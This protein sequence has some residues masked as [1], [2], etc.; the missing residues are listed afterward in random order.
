MNYSISLTSLLT[1]S[2]SISGM[3][4]QRGTSFSERVPIDLCAM[5]TGLS[6]R[7]RLIN[8][9][10][11][12]LEGE[13]S[14]S[15]IEATIGF[16]TIYGIQC[17][18]SN[19]TLKELEIFRN[20]KYNKSSFVYR[21]ITSVQLECVLDE[22]LFLHTS[23][24]KLRVFSHFSGVKMSQIFSGSVRLSELDSIQ[25]VFRLNMFKL[26]MFRLNM[27]RLNMFK[28]NMFR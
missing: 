12:L 19:P 13:T 11:F 2:L 23:I 6:F 7:L 8:G 20:K 27:L 10:E 22:S 18:L 15:S 4:G 17:N 1:A 26:N 9:N 3:D 25:I 28:L 24:D 5:S 14:S 21:D 16:C